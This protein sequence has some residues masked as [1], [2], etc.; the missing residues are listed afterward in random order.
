MQHAGLKNTESVSQILVKI[1]PNVLNYSLTPY[2]QS[3]RKVKMPVIQVYDANS[4][5]IFFL[6][7][8][9][10][11]CFTETNLIQ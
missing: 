4:V 11:P 7:K 5:I 6:S 9:T 3:N 2:F 1:R 8:K 10:P